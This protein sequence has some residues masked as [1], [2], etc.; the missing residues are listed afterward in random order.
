[1]NT[2]APTVA[3]EMAKFSGFT[4]NNGETV[5]KE[6]TTTSPGK[7]DLSDDE[8]KAGGK[9]VGGEARKTTDTATKPAKVELTDAEAD[10]ALAAA[11]DAAGEGAELTTEE[12]DE[13]LAA[14]LSEKQN[15]SKQPSG[16]DRA[17]KAQEGRRR[18]EARAARAEST[19]AELLRRLEA[20]EKG[21]TPLTADKKGGKDDTTTKEPDPK[22]YELGELD[23]KFIRDFTRWEVRQELAN[24]S[25][26]EETQQRASV[27]ERAEAEFKVKLEAFEDAGAAKYDDFQELVIDA[28]K[29]P[30]SDPASWP[31]TALVGQLILESEV[32]IDIA[33]ALASDHKEANRVAA[34]SPAAQR[35]WFARQEAKFT[36]DEGEGGES[37]GTQG[38]EAA[39]SRDTTQQTQ[40]NRKVTQ[41]PT[42]PKRNT[43][44]SGN[45]TVSGATTDFRAFEAM[46]AQPAKR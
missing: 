14:A 40:G 12:Q 25:K 37:E 29:L 41:A 1:M 19:N 30:K 38:K 45:R 28:A 23:V 26:N 44:A 42:I 21:T 2:K 11:Q 34:L 5:A 4:T 6:T 20:L 7:T 46:A 31:L 27:K 9:V 33:H 32:G 43:G 10:A 18:A 17:K 22:D 24:H 3:D 36:P 8:R 13:A 39:G 16:N 35:L 15:K